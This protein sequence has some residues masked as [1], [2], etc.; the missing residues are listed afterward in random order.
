MLSGCSA[1]Y[2]YSSTTNR[3]EIYNSIEE[4]S[5][6]IDCYAYSSNHADYYF[7]TTLKDKQKDNFVDIAEQILND[8][9]TDKVKFVVSTSFNTAYVGEVRNAKSTR[10]RNIDILYFNIQ[11]LSNINLL[12]ELN[13]KRYGEK[14]PYGLLYAYSYG[15]CVASNIIFRKQ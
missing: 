6:V 14:I 3:V 11:D 12:I 7:E 8:Y 15:Q 1:K 13:A 10:N 5:A 9:P 2:E 4:D